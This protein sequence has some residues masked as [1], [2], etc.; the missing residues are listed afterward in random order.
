MNFERHFLMNSYQLVLKYLKHAIKVYIEYLNNKH[1]PFRRL[2]KRSL[3][4]N[5]I[6]VLL[7]SKKLFDDDTCDHPSSHI[8]ESG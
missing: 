1:I 4:V 7:F 5:L 6:V 8:M 2:V 3:I